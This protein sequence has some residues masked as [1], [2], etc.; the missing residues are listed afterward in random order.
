VS[1]R[2]CCGPRCSAQ[3]TAADELPDGVRAE[4]GRLVPELAVASQRPA[5]LDSPGAQSRF[6][7]ALVTALASTA[8]DGRPAV[9]AVE[10]LQWVDGTSAEVLAVLL[11]RLR[12]LPLLLVLTWCPEM[13]PPRSALVGAVQDAARD[14]V[15]TVLQL[16]RLED[17]DVRALVRA[18]LPDVPEDPLVARLQAETGGLPVLVTEYLEAFRRSGRPPEGEGWQLPGGVRDLLQTRITALGETTQQVLAAAAVL[19]RDMTPGL[20]AHDER[21]QRGGGGAQPGGGDAQRPARGDRA[22]RQRL[23]LPAGRPAATGPRG[24]LP[25][26]PRL[27]HSRAADALAQRHRPD[28]P[29]AVALHLRLAGRTRRARS[30]RGA[31]PS[32]PWRCTRTRRRWSTCPLPRRSGIRRTS[33]STR[34]G[35]ADRARAVPAGADGVRRA[36]ATCPPTTGSPP[37]HWS[38]GSPR[39]TTGSVRGTSPTAT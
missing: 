31:P 24:H 5:P 4:V 1:S 7:K 16:G 12:E 35:R 6:W 39:C 15:G 10:D 27:L 11:R 3:G 18:A 8:G 32:T 34:P 22:Q 9:L 13:L 14:G 36:A 25:G 38:T 37:Q 23:R 21:A 28:A 2:T 17:E 19:H 30:G 20:G 26:P 33:S 29:A